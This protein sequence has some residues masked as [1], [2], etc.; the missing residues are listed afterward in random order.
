MAPTEVAF[1]ATEHESAHAALQHLDVSDADH[2]LLVAGRYV[3]VTHS[4]L[5]KLVEANVQFAFVIDHHGQIMTI[6]SS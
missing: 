1:W 5:E 6:P 3:T 2:A 4:E